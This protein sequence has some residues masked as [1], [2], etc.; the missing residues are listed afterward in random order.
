MDSVGKKAL[1]AGTWYTICTFI[2]KG[3]TFITMPIF[4]RVMSEGDIGNYSNFSSWVVILT[5][6]FTLDLFNTIN[7]AHYEYKDK[8]YEYMSSITLAGSLVTAGFYGI[9]C[10]FHKQ[11]TDWLG[12]SD[13]MLHMMFIYLII[14]PAIST[15]QAKFRIHMQYKYTILTSLLPSIGAV[16]T[17]LL[18]VG[19]SKPEDKLNGRITG[20]YGVWIA[21]SLAVYIFIL[22]K[23]RTFKKE[24]IR[25][26]LPIA[27]PL[28]IHTLANV[29]LSACDR[30]M[31]KRICGEVDTAYYSVAYSCSMVVAILWQAVNQ[32]WS[33]WCFEKMHNEKEGDILRVAK[34]IML[35]FTGLVFIVILLGP[36]LLYLMGG[37]KYAEAQYVLPPVMLGYVAQMMYTLYV[38][39]EYFMKKQKQIMIGTL[40]A[41]VINV[42]LNLIFIPIFGYIAA[43]YTTL[44]GY[45]CMLFIHYYFVRRMNMHKIYDMK[46]N[47]LILTGTILFGT[48]ISLLY[49]YDYVRWAIGGVAVLYFLQLVIRKRKELLRSLKKKDVEGLLR[50]FHLMK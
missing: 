30:V 33:P 43:A 22:A 2:L 17:A 31:I 9:A 14:T 18:L 3:L 32:A 29:V 19:I 48:A 49:P 23:G 13:F 47:I 7:L 42:V 36:E 21:A 27:I 10:I 28:V 16:L 12:I 35:L 38:N 20:Y 11:V 39:I 24:Y 1:K 44:V 37:E 25:F 5:S 15:L 41:A 46:F 4:N 40:I 26:A 34:P 6:V 45:V 50:V 8:I